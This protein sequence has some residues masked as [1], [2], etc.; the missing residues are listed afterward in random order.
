MAK[1]K[2]TIH[3]GKLFKMSTF[4]KYCNDFEHILGD[5]E[6]Q[7]RTGKTVKNRDS[8]RIG[9]HLANEQ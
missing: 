4:V 7:G 2:H 8:Q 6:E 3:K 9:Y 5:S 1:T